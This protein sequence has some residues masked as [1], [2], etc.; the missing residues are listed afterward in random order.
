MPLESIT[1]SGLLH[2]STGDVPE[3]EGMGRSPST[4]AMPADM[5]ALSSPDLDLS[6]LLALGEGHAVHLGADDVD[7]V[8]LARRDFSID[9]GEGSVLEPED[10]GFGDIEG[11]VGPDA[12]LRVVAFRGVRF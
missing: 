10:H 11:A 1:L 8:G 4:G 3:D 12:D 2:H 7:P 6:R 9:V 5:H